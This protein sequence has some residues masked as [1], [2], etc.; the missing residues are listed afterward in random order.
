MDMSLY[1][2]IIDE[3]DDRMNH[4][5][6]FYPFILILRSF[7]NQKD[8]DGYDIPTLCL[9]VLSFLIYEG[10][11]KYKGLSL[12]DIVEFMDAFIKEAYSEY[13]DESVA[14]KYTAIVLDKL[15]NE[16]KNYLFTH[17]SFHDRHNKQKLMKLIE[18]KLD[19]TGNTVL[20]HVTKEGLDFFL[21]TKEFPE[22]T[23][24]TINLLLFRKQIEK[25]SFDF[26]LETVKRLNLEVQRK[27]EKKNWILELLMVGGKEG[28]AAYREYHENAMLQFKEENELFKDV[29]HLLNNVSGE[30]IDKLNKKLITDKETKAFTILKQ[31]E[32]GIHNA[33]EK[34]TKLLHEAARLTKEYDQIL[35]LRTKA[36]F[37]ERF[38]FEGELEKIATQTDNPINLKYIIEPLLMPNKRKSFNILKA[39]SPQRLLTDQKKDS[40]HERDELEKIYLP[41]LD[42]LT[43]ERVNKNFFVYAEH[44]L[45]MLT[46]VREFDLKTWCE[47]LSDTYGEKV[48]TNGDFISFIIEINRGKAPGSLI[49]AYH[50]DQNVPLSEDGTFE[51]MEA[52]LKS[53]VR[54]IKKDL[55]Y[56]KLEVESI[57]DHDVDLGLGLKITDMIFRGIR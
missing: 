56:S 19:E 10:R 55:P 8:D 53:T 39:L 27:I 23:Q 51:N 57:P 37:S 11:L 21:K 18:M 33:M 6:T 24:I 12:T 25:G 35:K 42:E 20:Y 4:I 28:T 2:E 5:K 32:D 44:L 9:A 40:D 30:Y 3:M 48:I 54:K 52:L 13:V 14:K 47:N 7:E 41:T 22:E 38:N 16:G 34:H 36:A 26:A 15:Q 50:I 1:K 17:Y 45:Y 31:I 49:K 29:N 46:E 43:R